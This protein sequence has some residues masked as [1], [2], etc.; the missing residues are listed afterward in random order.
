MGRL[1]VTTCIVGQIRR[2]MTHKAPA[3]D[4]GLWGG[5]LARPERPGL[6]RLGHRSVG[7]RVHMIVK[8]L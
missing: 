4:R 7:G 1:L 6:D 3:R 8:G 2:I 5:L